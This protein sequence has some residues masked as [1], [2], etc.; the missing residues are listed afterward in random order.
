MKQIIK[1]ELIAFQLRLQTPV[2]QPLTEPALI[3]T[4]GTLPPYVI[5]DKDIDPHLM[6]SMCHY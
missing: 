4:V 3:A 2:P 6:L 5:M 1:L